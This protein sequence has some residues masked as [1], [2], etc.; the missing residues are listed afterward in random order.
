MDAVLCDRHEMPF[1]QGTRSRTPI[2]LAYLVQNVKK[3]DSAFVIRDWSST[4]ALLN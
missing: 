3:L 4:I 2:L 1:V